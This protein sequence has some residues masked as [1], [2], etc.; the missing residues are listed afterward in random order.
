MVVVGRAKELYPSN[1]SR[2]F[3]FYDVSSFSALLLPRSP[4]RP[5]LVRRPFLFFR[6]RA[7]GRTGRP[8]KGRPLRASGR[9][10]FAFGP[11][12]LARND[13]NVKDERN[14]DGISPGV[15]QRGTGLFAG[16]G[17]RGTANTSPSPQLDVAIPF[18]FSCSFFF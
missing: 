7:H 17:L 8:A 4:S 13:M 6:L 18:F 3:S 12:G 10:N 14:G 16:V 11:S 15:R 9:A 1:R 5:V 2:A